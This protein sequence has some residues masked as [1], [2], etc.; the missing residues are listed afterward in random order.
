MRGGAQGVCRLLERSGA[1]L[2]PVPDGYELRLGHDG[3]RRPAAHLSEADLLAVLA[4]R[5]LTRR[6]D[7]RLFLCGPDEGRAPAQRRPQGDGDEAGLSGLIRR[8]AFPRHHLLA[9]AQWRRDHDM[10][11]A[12]AHLTLDWSRLGGGG[13]ASA[14]SEAPLYRLRARKRCEEARAALGD[15]EPLA[16]RAGLEDW[17]LA[18]AERSCGLRPGTGAAHLAQAFERLSAY[19][20]IEG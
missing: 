7:G 19:Y 8:K 14:A 16:R 15:L 6:P 13:R 5:P 3:R 11:V 2:R 17:G 18:A 9:L 4:L 20:R 1:H 12:G 10:A